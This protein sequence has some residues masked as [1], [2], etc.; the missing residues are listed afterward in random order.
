MPK[1]LVLKQ[2]A[3]PYARNKDDIVYVATPGG[4]EENA[5]KEGTI[6]L[7]VEKVEAKPKV[8]RALPKA[9]STYTRKK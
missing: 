1:Y 2:D 4:I 5:L 6:E 9:K 7:Y 3:L 8:A